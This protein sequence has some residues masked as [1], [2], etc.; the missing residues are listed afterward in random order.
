MTI[1]EHEAE[2]I[3]AAIEALQLSNQRYGFISV[4]EPD[5]LELY[6]KISKSF[7]E[8]PLLLTRLL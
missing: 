2:V 1:T 8:I 5:E 4:L 7:P 3:V 6:K